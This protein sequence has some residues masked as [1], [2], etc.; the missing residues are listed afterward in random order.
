MFNPHPTIIYSRLVRVILLDLFV[1]LYQFT[2][3]PVFG[4]AHVR[5]HDYFILYHGQLPYLNVIEKIKL[6]IL[7]V[8]PMGSLHMLA[9]RLVN[10]AVLVPNQAHPASFYCS[11]RRYPQ[12]VN[13]GDAE[14]SHSEL[15][16]SLRRQLR[17]KGSE[18]QGPP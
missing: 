17:Q 10:Q 15:G 13:Y 7:F 16:A 3:L 11:A 1:S 5:R 4:I 12:F 2:C 18:P 14:H 8:C 9:T 6:L